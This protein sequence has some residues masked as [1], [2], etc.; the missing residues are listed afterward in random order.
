MRSSIAKV[1][2]HLESESLYLILKVLGTPKTLDVI[3]QL[4]RYSS[5]IREDF[6]S[7][8]E[9]IIKNHNLATE[10]DL[11]RLEVE[12]RGLKIRFSQLKVALLTQE[13]ECLKD[14]QS[15]SIK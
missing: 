5:T 1:L 11:A 4:N 8:L 12:I 13:I 6:L 7:Q 3:R 9:D 10:T 2:G 14:K 15:S